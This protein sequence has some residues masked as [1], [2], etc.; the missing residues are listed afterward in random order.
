MEKIGNKLNSTEKLND[1]EN[2]DAGSAAENQN[3]KKS[4]EKAKKKFEFTKENINNGSK[5]QAIIDYLNG[6]VA[7]QL[8]QQV[9]LGRIDDVTAKRQLLATQTRLKE[10]NRDY[11]ADHNDEAFLYIAL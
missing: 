8:K 10:L 3:K 9:G 6:E 11:N 4:A 1:M 5:R 2:L 7:S